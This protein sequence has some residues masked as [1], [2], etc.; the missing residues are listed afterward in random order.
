MSAVSSDNKQVG[1]TDNRG[2]AR[3]VAH[4]EEEVEEVEEEAVTVCGASGKAE[5]HGSRAGAASPGVR[6]LL[7]LN[8]G[9]VQES[10][11]E[12]NWTC[13]YQDKHMSIVLS[14][15]QQNGDLCSLHNAA[16]QG[17]PALV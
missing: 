9:H 13:I 14:T 6:A 8:T 7:H 2:A 5:A 3:Q 11:P 15:V 10:M 16:G 12:V 1:T 17:P 4:D